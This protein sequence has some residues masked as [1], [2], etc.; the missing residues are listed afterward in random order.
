MQDFELTDDFHTFPAPAKINLFLHV[1]GQ[2]EDG[3]HL[4]QTVFRLLDYYDTVHIRPR[5][6]GIIRRVANI[7]NVPEDEDLCVRAARLIKQHTNSPLG[8]DIVLQ[9]HI[10]MGGG[11]GGGSSDAATVLLALNHLWTLGLSRK[12]MQILGLKLGADVPV[13]VFGQNAW[14]EGIGEELQPIALKPAWY[15]VLTPPVHVSTAEVFASKELTRNTIPTTIAAFSG[16]PSGTGSKH[17]RIQNDLESVVCRQY[18]VIA[19]CLSW[20]NQFSQAR[21][22]GSGA[23]VFAEFASRAEAEA[24]LEK[25]AEENAGLSAEVSVAGFLAHGLNKHPLYHLAA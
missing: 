11:L 9:K 10:P 17:S 20:L 12:E 2:R 5:T 14:A 24:V 3:Y 25:L 4:L 6:D 1:I 7:P 19:S 23:S 21:M 16:E 18:P 13:F 8:A 15:V 22:S